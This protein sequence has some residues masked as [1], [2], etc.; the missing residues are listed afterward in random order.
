MID[1]VTTIGFVGFGEVASRFAP[2]LQAGGATVVAYDVLLDRPG[3]METLAARAKGE[4]PRM[5]PLD[6]MIANADIVL[7]TVT[8]DVARAAAQTCAAHLGP[9]NT[10]V[11]LNAASPG[12]KREIAKVVATSGAEFVEGAIL[13]AVNVMGAK[14]QVL[15]CGRKAAEIA[16]TMTKLGLNFS[17]YGEEIGK[18]SSFKML[19]SVFSKGMEALLVECLLA[20]R[21][22]GVEADLWREI[23]ATLDAASFEEVG[24]NWVRTHATAHARRYH[25]MVQV[26][27]LLREMGVDAPMTAGTVALFERSGKVGLKDRFAHAPKTATEVVAALDAGLAESV[28]RS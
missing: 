16:A 8:T 9:R 1:T 2:A 7:S 15:L 3:G 19:R 22:A 17:A 25:E 18:A 12:L 4:A 20:G 6:R 13:P 27:A 14:S 10:Y 26:E 23:V 11:D 24:G 28:P 5:M 21:R